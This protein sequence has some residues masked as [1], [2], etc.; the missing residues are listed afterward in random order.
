MR[1]L[2]NPECYHKMCE[3]C[4]DRIF[5]QGPAPCPVAGCAK[6]LRKQRFRK[7]TFEDLQIEREVDIRRRVA[8]VFNRRQDEF[9]SLLAYNNYLEEVETLT[10]NLIYGID[11]ATTEA[12]LAA[13][14]SQNAPVIAA[15]A[16][17]SSEESANVDASLAAR[18][19]QARL[20]REGARQEELD[21]RADQA[22]ARRE[23]QDRL[24]GSK[25]ADPDTTV[26]ETQRVVLKKSTA[27]RTNNN[28]NSTT[29]DDSS[30]PSPATAQA[31]PSFAPVYKIQGLKPIVMPEPE[32]A[33]DPFGGLALTWAYHNTRTEYEHSWLDKARTDAAITA[34]GYD[35]REYCARAMLEAF[36]GLGVFVAEEFG[37]RERE[38]EKEV[39]TSAAAVAAGE[40]EPG[41]SMRVDGDDVF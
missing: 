12:K 24:A 38:S 15:N 26:K 39:A 20:Q 27:R 5:S 36:G 21:E 31:T 34:G 17:R 37:Q 8:A 33:Y 25:T 35:V 1:F 22:E 11:V 6:T 4:V 10:F 19:E 3:S 29:A 9:T 13:Y 14:A 16:A 41:E 32:K 7:A 28:I 23:V 40:G 2:V 30:A 18:M